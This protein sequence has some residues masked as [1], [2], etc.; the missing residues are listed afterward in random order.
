MDDKIELR[1]SQAG[2]RFIAQ[3]T[4]FNSGDFERMHAYI[5]DSYHPDLLAEEPLAERLDDF[6]YQR[7]VLGRLKVVQL[8]GTGKHHVI[9]LMEAE[10]SD[11]Y[12]LN[13]L[14][15]EEDYPHRIIGYSL[16]AMSSDD[17]SESDAESDADNSAGG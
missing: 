16:T 1:A 4:I 7:E 2:M 5:V 13:D 9:V 8:L 6:Q 15:V 14:Q 11:D 3:T 12:I 10:L 17:E